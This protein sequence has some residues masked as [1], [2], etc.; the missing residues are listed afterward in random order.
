MFGQWKKYRSTKSKEELTELHGEL[1]TFIH[2]V[3][4]ISLISVGGGHFIL[5]TLDLIYQIKCI[6]SKDIEHLISILY[7]VKNIKLKKRQY[8]YP[9]RKSFV[10]GGNSSNGPEVQGRESRDSK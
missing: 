6:K 10:C 9:E 4:M 1:Q 2:T 8:L 5:S 7:T 3:F